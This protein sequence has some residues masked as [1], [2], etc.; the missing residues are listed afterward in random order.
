MRDLV[1]EG[2]PTEIEDFDTRLLVSLGM[3][4]EGYDLLS[5]QMDLRL[6]SGRLLRP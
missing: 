6:R 2:Y 1:E 4:A 5:A 3:L